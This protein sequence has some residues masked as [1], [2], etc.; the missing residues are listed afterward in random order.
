[1][2]EHLNPDQSIESQQHYCG[3]LEKVKHAPKNAA[4]EKGE[5]LLEER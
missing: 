3:I 4:I 1:M 5:K 2:E